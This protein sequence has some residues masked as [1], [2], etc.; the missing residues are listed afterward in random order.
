MG[1]TNRKTGLWLGE[2]AVPYYIFRD[3]DALV[4]LA[5]PK[6]GEVPLDPAS[7]STVATNS[8]IRRFRKDPEAFSRLSGAA[9]LSTQKAE[10]FDMVFLTGGH[11]AMWDFSDNPSLKQL[12]ED[13]NRQH[14]PIGAVCHG[15]AG[16]VA[17]ENS[18]GEPL[19]KG[20]R[21]TAFSNKE[22]EAAG[23]AGIVP[24]LL[25]SK[26]VSLGASYNKGADF[27]SHTVADGNIITGQNPA[28][29]MEVAKQLL[30]AA[31]A[32]PKVVEASLN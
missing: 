2:L 1:D 26:L 27:I 25:E 7:E 20:R 6:G 19:V 23:L 28:S 31:K 18:A 17:L 29:S 13:F 10:D 30:A 15:V 9:V 5:S 3:A 16:L 8:T 4:T 21:L 11:G 32:L 14:K 24:Y 22:E 12:L